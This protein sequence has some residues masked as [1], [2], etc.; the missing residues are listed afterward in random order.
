[1]HPRA[2]LASQRDALAALAG[3]AAL[4]WR[5][6]LDA[7]ALAV[8]AAGLRLRREMRTPP[9]GA[10]A[11]DALRLRWQRGAARAVPDLAVRLDTLAQNLAHLS[12]QR[13]LERGYAIVTRAD[14]EVVQDAASLTRGEDVAITFARGRAGAK[15]TD[16][17]R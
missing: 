10:V 5:R 17:E 8:G 15:V 4:A 12:P 14:D 2:R 7:R 9:A 1:V 3:R 11:L 13:V 6:V 16:V